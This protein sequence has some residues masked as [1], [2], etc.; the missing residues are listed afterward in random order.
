MRRCNH[1]VA[2]SVKSHIPVSRRAKQTFLLS[3]AFWAFPFFFIRLTLLTPVGVAVQLELVT[4]MAAFVGR[5]AGDVT[6]MPTALFDAIRREMYRQEEDV[7]QR[8]QVQ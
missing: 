5:G 7:W 3:A 4:D 8:R 2:Y 1:S 6:C